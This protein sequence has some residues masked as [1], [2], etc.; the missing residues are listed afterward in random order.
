MKGE[1]SETHSNIKD[2]R[3]GMYED[4]IAQNDDTMNAFFR[5]P[6]ESFVLESET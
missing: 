6:K 3:Q 4:S 2:R 5:I 1:R